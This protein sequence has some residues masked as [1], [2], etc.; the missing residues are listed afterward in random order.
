MVGRG[1]AGVRLRRLLVH[2][3][4]RRGP[5]R[6]PRDWRLVAWC[7]GVFLVIGLLAIPFPQ[8]LGN[9][10]GPAQLG[11]DSALGLRLAATLLVLKLLITTGSLRAGAEGGLLTPGLTIGALLAILLGGLWTLVFPAV[12][13]GAFAIVGA[14]AFLASSMA[15]PITAIALIAEFTRVDHDFLVP[16]FFAVAG[17]AG[18]LRLCKRWYDPPRPA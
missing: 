6:A 8:L 2:A 4:G 1:R 13:P 3:G 16:I 12:P 5:A 14:G 9:G 10:K 15:M 17:S 7:L 18:M 11:F